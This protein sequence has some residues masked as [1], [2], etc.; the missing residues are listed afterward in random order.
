MNSEQI[1]WNNNDIFVQQDIEKT[2]LFT[3]KFKVP[4]SVLFK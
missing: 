4:S 3:I 2:S 1:Y